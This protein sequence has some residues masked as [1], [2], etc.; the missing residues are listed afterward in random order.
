MRHAQLINL[1]GPGLPQLPKTRQ[2]GIETPVGIAQRWPLLQC[3]NPGGARQDIFNQRRAGPWE[4]GQH[5]MNPGLPRHRL[6]RRCRKRL[7]ARPPDFVSQLQQPFGVGRLSG[8]GV[9][10]H[11]TEPRL[12]V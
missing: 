9:G 6:D 2:I 12:A 1:G 5:D 11:C 8:K 3:L 10:M 4:P 7:A